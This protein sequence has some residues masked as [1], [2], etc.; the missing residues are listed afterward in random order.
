MDRVN[1]PRFSVE[2]TRVLRDWNAY[3]FERHEWS[4]C[5]RETEAPWS[6]VGF[7]SRRTYLG[8]RLWAW[9][10]LRNKGKEKT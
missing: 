6:I 8:A 4:A 7:G 3:G 9:R 1:K 5:I 2:F 10:W